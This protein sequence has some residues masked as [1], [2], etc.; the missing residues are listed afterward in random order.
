MRK[1]LEARPITLDHRVDLY[2]PSHCICGNMLPSEIRDPV[3]AEVKMNFD[4]WFGANGESAIKGDWRLPDGTVAQEDVS[5]VYSFC[6][7]ES[8]SEH[9]GDVDRLAVYIANRL[10]QDR[11]LR[12]FDNLRAA[13]WPNTIVGLKPKSNCACKGRITEWANRHPDAHSIEKAD[14]VSKLRVTHGILRSFSSQ[15]HARTLFC[16]ILNYGYSSGKLPVTKW[17]P[18]LRSLLVREPAVLCDKNGFQIVHIHFI[19][20][21]LLRSA[22]QQV[23][24]RIH[25]DNPS[26]RGLIIA[27]NEAQTAWELINAKTNVDSNDFS[28]RRIKVGVEAAR[29]TTERLFALMIAES[30]ELLTAEKLKARHDRA[31]DVARVTSRCGTR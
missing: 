24:R 18:H 4:S 5:D 10:T 2:V 11:V 8:L 20:R 9:A 21:R 22:E 28:L 17:P 1:T 19:S 15:E 12:V 27:S 7:R 25:K 13:L 14:Q 31:F 23:I 16:D 6:S 26:F 29:T 3:L 30:E